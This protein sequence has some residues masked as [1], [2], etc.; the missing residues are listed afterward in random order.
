MKNAMQAELLA[1]ELALMDRDWQRAQA[2]ARKMRELVGT[3]AS[4]VRLEVQGLG[5]RASGL[6]PL[7]DVY[8]QV[9]ALYRGLNGLGRE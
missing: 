8:D 7:L 5:P 6:H 9:D 4:G 1:L 3:E 2:S